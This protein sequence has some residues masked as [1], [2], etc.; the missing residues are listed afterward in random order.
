MTLSPPA[1][2]RHLLRRLYLN[3]IGLPPRPDEVAAFVADNRPEAIRDVVDQL[4]GSPQ[5]GERWARHWL[6]LVHFA[7]THGHAQDRIRTNAWP[8][9]DYV[10][11]AFNSDKPYARFVEEQIA[12]DALFPRDPQASVALGFLA[13]GPWDESS[14]RDIREESTDRQIARYIDRDD[15]VATT[16]NTFTST[17]AQC[18]RCHD[19]KFDPVSLSDYYGLQAVFAGT[20]KG[21]R[22]YDDDPELHQRRQKLLKQ[23]RAI[24]NRSPKFLHELL[25]PVFQEKVAQWEDSMSD[26]I[27]FWTPLKPLDAAGATQ[28]TLKIRHNYTINSRGVTAETNTYHVAVATDYPGITALKLETLPDEVF[29]N[30]GPGRAASGNFHLTNIRIRFATGTETNDLKIES[31]AADFNQTG[32]GIEKAIDSDPKTGWGIHPQVGRPHAAVFKFVEP[33]PAPGRF[34]IDLEQNHGGY[35]FIARFRFLAATSTPPAQITVLPEQIADTLRTAKSERCECEDEDLA[36]HVVTEDVERAM[37]QLPPGKLV[38]AGAHEFVRDTGHKPIGRVRPVHILRRGELKLAG[39]LAEPG[40]LSCVP[41]LSPAFDLEEPDDESA[42]RASLAKWMTDHRNVLTWRSIVNRV[43]QYHF[44]RGIVA[45][46]NDFGKMG[47]PP[48]HPELLDWLA[49]W[50]QENG[51][52]FK[53]L[54]RLILL[55]ATYQ[56]SS[57]FNANYAER[58]GENRL[59][60][61]M[62]P[63]RLDAEIVRDG[64]LAITGKIDFSMGGPSAQQF[65]LAPGLH[66]TPEVDYTKFDVDSHA[67]FRRSIYRFIFRTLPDPMME[68][69]DCPDPS[70]LTPARNNSVSVLQALSMW[71]NKFIV[72]QSEHF[73]NRLTELHPGD[74]SRQ[75]NSACNLV[76]SRNAGT[77]EK[78]ELIAFAREHG[79]PNLCRVL[80]NSNEFM[81]VH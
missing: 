81:F 25:G 37:A 41:G 71:N 54:H 12:G 47:Q 78:S 67:S 31:A 23:N 40:A 33:T 44:G 30:D 62:N 14:L 1:D 28:I 20:E 32:Y 64:I 56:Q 80:L 35:H 74:L 75:V 55:S 7:E 36:W 69:L 39:P 8:Y 38:Y 17:T 5:Y 9:R 73:A 68:A 63:A 29:P 6:D 66:V 76:Y 13:T 16:F 19:H 45:T 79:L 70:Q 53:Q 15:I 26:A 61:R 42:R 4:L 46:A 49:I 3:L 50:F 51:G 43:W 27:Q 59:L 58:D 65:V 34:L 11:N 60:W 77:I 24:K 21:D 52:S 72:R 48:S 10:I 57:A 22:F 18:A 2:K